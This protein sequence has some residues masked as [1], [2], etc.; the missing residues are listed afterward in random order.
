MDG[1]GLYSG[2]VEVRIQKSGKRPLTLALSPEYG[3]EGKEEQIMRQILAVLVVIGW[4]SVL[5][6]GP[7]V[8][9]KKLIEFGWDE[10]TTQYMRQHITEM[11]KTPLDGTV[12]TAQWKNVGGGGGGDFMWDCWSKRAF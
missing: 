1:G 8:E 10:P 12:F 5:V 11:E 3:G 6:A 2:S 4:S 9:K 7:R